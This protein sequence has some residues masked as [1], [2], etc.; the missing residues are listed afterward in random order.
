MVNLFGFYFNIWILLVLAIAILFLSVVWYRRSQSYLLFSNV[1]AFEASKQFDYSSLPN[2]LFLLSLILFAIALTD[3]HTY[4]KRE[5]ENNLPPSTEGIAIYLVLDKSGSMGQEINTPGKSGRAE[6]QTKLS[7]MKEVT[8]KFIAERRSDLIGIVAFA[9]Q[10]DVLA[11]LT[12]DH[13]AVEEALQRLEQ[14]SG[15]EN[16]GTAIGYAIYKTASLIDATRIY[17]ETGEKSVLP[18][19]VIENNVIILVTDGLQDPNPLDSSNQLRSIGLEEAAAFAAEKGVK[20]YLINVDPKM[21]TERFAPQRRQMERITNLTGGKFYIVDSAKGL[22]NVYRDINELEKSLLP[23]LSF[24]LLPEW[25][26]RVNFYPW[27]IAIGLVSF[28]LAI[29]FKTVVFRRVP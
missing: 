28:L 12:L 14:V 5:N 26:K 15:K 20:L 23:D 27:L 11:P 7:L 24:D 9:R 6:V 21:A 2:W 19:Y 1:S 17:N 10:A 18:A 13:A 29:I 16:D 8:A 22:E 4:T 25:Y 3:P